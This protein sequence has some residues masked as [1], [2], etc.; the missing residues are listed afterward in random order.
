VRT[1]KSG[2]RFSVKC[3]LT[4]VI[5]IKAV[6]LSAQ[7][8][9]VTP[10][11]PNDLDNKFTPAKST[12]FNASDSYSSGSG[13][14]G[15]SFKN[16]IKNNISL[17]PRG[18]AAFGYERFLTDEIS[19]EGWLGV[20][21]KKDQI[22]TAF[23][24]AADESFGDSQSDIRLE[25]IYN[26]GKQ[27]GSSLYYGAS[28]KFHYSGWWYFTDVDFAF[29]ELGVRSY[30]NKLNIASFSSNSNYNY[31]NAPIVGSAAVKVQH[32]NYILNYGIRLTTEGKIKTSHEF[33]VGAGIRSSTYDSF[34]RTENQNNYPYPNSPDTYSK[35]GTQ[36]RE[37][38]FMFLVGYE[39]G[40]GF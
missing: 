13:S 21:Y 20:A 11:S 16:V 27:T 30:S 1:N 3:C 6:F 28:V 22:F 35:N 17:W 5:L 18:I 26:C 14:G 36:A 39:L 2:P 12:V 8:Q 4:T 9:P 24:S 40:F 32:I 23:G 10:G 7:V 34:T 15:E 38:F 29:L 19:M 37:T 31:Y 25:P 33:Y